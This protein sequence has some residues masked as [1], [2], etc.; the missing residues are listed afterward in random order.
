MQ[1]VNFVYWEEEGA[2][3]GY[4]QEYPDYWTQGETLE[5][6]EEHLRDLYKDLVSGEI[7]GIRK[8]RELVVA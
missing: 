4:L 6:L 8:V 1:K 5:D 2:W 7:P 3:L